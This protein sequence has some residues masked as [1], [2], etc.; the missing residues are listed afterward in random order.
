MGFIHHLPTSF[1]TELSPWLVNL[2]F[3][4]VQGKSTIDYMGGKSSKALDR[5][6]DPKDFLPISRNTRAHKEQ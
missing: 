6:G 2:A 4:A 3:E 1:P 5:G